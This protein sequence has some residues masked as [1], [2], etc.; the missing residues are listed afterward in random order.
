MTLSVHQISARQVRAIAEGISTGTELQILALAQR[1]KALAML[2]MVARSAAEAR[3]PEA[4]AAAAGWDLLTRVQRKTPAAV[5][6]LLRYPSTAAWACET[7]LAFGSPSRPARPGH[8]AVIATAAAIRGGASCVAELP[9]AECAG[10]ELHLPSLGSVRLLREF[11]GKAAVLRHHDGTT[12]I[13]AGNAKMVLPRRLDADGPGW[14]PLAT[15]TANSG[16]K[17]LRLVMDDADPF[18]L[19]GYDGPL[20]RLSDR[21]RD[22][23]RRRILGGWRLLVRDHQRTAADLLTL[24]S[25]LTPLSGADGASRSITSRRAFGTIGLSL[26]DDD[27]AAA[28]ILTHEVQHAKLC[29]LM[30]LVPMVTESA[31]ALYY[32]PWRSDPRPLVSLL[33]GMYA[34]LGVAR[35]WWHHREVAGEPFE[36][37]RAHVEFARWRTACAQVAK[38]VS[39][40]PELTKG[41]RAFVDGMVRVLG[42]WRHEYVPPAAQEEAD[43]AVGEHQRQWETRRRGGN[44]TAQRA[45]TGYESR[46]QPG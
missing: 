43:A 4:G 30:D 19:P 7:L 13:C 9:A 34:H 24:I 1:S 40:Q 16:R 20:E 11:R 8:L 32:A 26:P 27:V 44:G 6:A 10:L 36:V 39:D 3:H 5:E 22:E 28:L 14:R 41:G 31:S 46:R 35:F 25:A 18:R 23:W 38:V 15:V 42:G 12:E 37:H 33:Q 17:R 45:E 29:A 21:Q 2:A